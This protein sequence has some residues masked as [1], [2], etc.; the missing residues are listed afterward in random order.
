[1]V[2][3]ESL[4]LLLESIVILDY[5]DIIVRDMVDIAAYYKMSPSQGGIW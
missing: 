5:W 2:M 4:L 1:M 3:T